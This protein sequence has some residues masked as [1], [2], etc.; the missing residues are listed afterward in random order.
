MWKHMTNDIILSSDL[1]ACL[2]AVNSI[3]ASFFLVQVHVDLSN[4]FTGEHNF[5]HT[6]GLKGQEVITS[7]SCVTARWKR[8]FETWHLVS[9][10]AK[11]CLNY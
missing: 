7:K 5:V 1:Q 6:R 9:L 4:Y 3:P 10:C 8:T 2:Q 11:A